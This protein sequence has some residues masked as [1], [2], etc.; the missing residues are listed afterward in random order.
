MAHMSI[1]EP[2]RPRS[3]AELRG[4]TDDDI[5]A[6]YDR[7]APSTAMGTAQFREELARRDQER[8]DRAMADYARRMYWLT[9]IIAVAT[10]VNV[11]VF[12]AR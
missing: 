5:V 9:V 6:L 10:L 12:V 4:L 1:S 11:F 8:H 7:V 3:M 2:R